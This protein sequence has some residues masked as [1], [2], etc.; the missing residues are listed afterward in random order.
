MK[1]MVKRHGN[2]LL[3]MTKFINLSL[4]KLGVKIWI[5]YDF[6]SL[7]HFSSL[8]YIHTTP[9]KIKHKSYTS[10]IDFRLKYFKNLVNVCW[11]NCIKPTY[12]KLKTDNCFQSR[13]YSYRVKPLVLKFENIKRESNNKRLVSQWVKKNL[14][15]LF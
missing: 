9:S 13:F 11:Q 3:D 5:H 14:T 15:A 8:K 2:I 12:N 6:I 7:I 1:S 4:L 10:T